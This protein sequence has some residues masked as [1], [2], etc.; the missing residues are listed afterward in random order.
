MRFPLLGWSQRFILVLAIL[1]VPTLGRADPKPITED[2]FP[3]LIGASKPSVV[4]IETTKKI[5]DTFRKTWGYE[6]YYGSGTLI[7]HRGET[8]VL[9]N[10]HVVI[11]TID[12]KVTIITKRGE[13]K[14]DGVIDSLDTYTDLALVALKTKDPQFLS[15]IRTI[16]FDDS[17]KVREGEWV[18]A[19]GNPRGFAF[20]SQ[21]GIVS[22]LGRSIG[23]GHDLI[24]HDFIQIDADINPGNSGGPLINLRGKVIGIVT[25]VP[26]VY[27]GG[28]TGIGFAI[29]INIA[30]DFLEK[31]SLGKQGGNRAGWVGILTQ[32]LEEDL[33]EMYKHPKDARGLLVASVEKPSPAYSAGLKQGDLLLSIKYN[34]ELRDVI[35]PSEFERIISGISTG[36]SILVKYLRGG[37]TQEVT[38]KVAPRPDQ[39][40]Q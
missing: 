28:S 5:F 31:R 14:V 13:R 12:I 20:T 39:R 27:G 40:Q 4:H 10:K 19:I 18:L 33:I 37:K 3:D 24:P 8:K 16:H 29:P 38:V 30:K 26:T 36:E 35:S 34:G 23:I 2:T 1:S 22:A 32:A 6:P 17:D 15:E 21:K 25:A 11:D 7:T 9:T